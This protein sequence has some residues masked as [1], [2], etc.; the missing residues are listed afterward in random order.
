M[1]E[2]GWVK[3][4]RGEADVILVFVVAVGLV[5]EDVVMAVVVVVVVGPTAVVVIV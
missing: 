4:S 1:T 3:E 2:L 5:E